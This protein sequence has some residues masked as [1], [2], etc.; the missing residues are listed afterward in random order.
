MREPVWVPRDQVIQRIRQA[1]WTFKKSGR[2]TDLWK[3]TG[4]PQRLPVPKRKTFPENAVRIVLSQAGLS[5][6][7]IEEFLRCSVKGD[8][9]KK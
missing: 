6:E 4:S 7:Q 3:L 8:P 2:K 1:N 9:S 5:K